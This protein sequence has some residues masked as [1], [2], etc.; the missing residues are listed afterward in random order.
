[1]E[2]LDAPLKNIQISDLGQASKVTI[3]KNRRVIESRAKYT[4][5]AVLSR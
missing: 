5:F 4:N 3:D 1:M 2:G